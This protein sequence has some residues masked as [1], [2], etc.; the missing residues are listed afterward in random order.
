MM[1][2]DTNRPGSQS[3]IGANPETRTVLMFLLSISISNVF[4]K[5]EVRSRR[6]MCEQLGGVV[7]VLIAFAFEVGFVN[8]YYQAFS[9]LLPMIP[10][11]PSLTLPPLSLFVMH[12]DVA[13][14]NTSG[15]PQIRHHRYGI[16]G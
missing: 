2:T 7:C 6:R 15:R 10:S 13:I 4:G 14:K 11:I 3:S 1:M 5:W 9:S 8:F 12:V 16:N